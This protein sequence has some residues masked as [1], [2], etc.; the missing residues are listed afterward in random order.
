MG[1]ISEDSPMV[2]PRGLRP[3]VRLLCR[4][5]L[6]LC[7]VSGAPLHAQPIAP[8][9]AFPDPV[10]YPGSRRAAEIARAPEFGADAFGWL[11]LGRV[12]WSSG[13]DQVVT[14][15]KVWPQ[16]G[17]S[18][19]RRFLSRSAQLLTIEATRHGAAALLGRDPAYVVCA[20]EGVWRRLGHATA[21]VVTDFDV[22]GR[23][24][25]AWP[26]ML[27][28]T[29]GALVLGR[30]QPGQGAAETV[31]VRAVTTIGASLLGNVAKEFHFMLGTPSRST[32]EYQ[33]HNAPPATAHGARADTAAHP[34]SP[35]P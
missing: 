35:L 1:A 23:R 34:R 7:A 8:A 9:S 28:A 12:L 19:G 18:Y 14:S 2:L 29:A 31:A 10:P 21:G 13:Y 24:R 15:P 32:I 33:H 30:L 17:E 5:G 22:S 25:A 3:A 4:A 16:D 11:A 20:C 6:A 26:R 27:G